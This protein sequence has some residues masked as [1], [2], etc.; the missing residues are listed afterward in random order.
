MKDK[1]YD[2]TKEDTSAPGNSEQDSAGLWR[3]CSFRM[4][5]KTLTIWTVARLLSYSNSLFQ[6]LHDESVE[7]DIGIWLFDRKGKWSSTFIK[8]VHVT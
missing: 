1:S 3:H 4:A 7:P 2:N 8:A 5:G 6:V